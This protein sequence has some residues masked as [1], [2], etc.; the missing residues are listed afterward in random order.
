MIAIINTG[1][2]M[3]GVCNYNLQINKD[4]ITTFTHDRRD[5]LAKCL[6]LASE[7]ADNA[8]RDRSLERFNMFKELQ[9]F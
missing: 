7:A 6:M 4:L 2:D 5:G 1:G 8:T 3:D 9:K